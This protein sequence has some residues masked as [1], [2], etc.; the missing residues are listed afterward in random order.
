MLVYKL[1]FA[2]AAFLIAVNHCADISSSQAV[3][4]TVYLQSHDIVINGHS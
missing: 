4:R 2:D 1:D 3:G